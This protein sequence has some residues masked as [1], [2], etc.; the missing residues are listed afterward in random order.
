MRHLDTWILRDPYSIGHYYSTGRV[1]QESLRAMIQDRQICAPQVESERPVVE[2]LARNMSHQ[3]GCGLLQRLPP[4][5][6]LIIYGYVFGD[7]AVHLVQ[8]KGKIRHVRCQHPSASIANHRHCCPETPARWRVSS[9]AMAMLY[10]HTHASLP[11]KL[12]NSSLSLLRTCRAIYLEAADMPYSNLAF[13]VDDLHTFVAFSLAICP[14]RLRCIKRL[15]VQWTP[16]WQPMTGE[17]SASS[18]Y[19]HTH[20]DQLWRLFWSRVQALTGLE[21]LQFSLDLG[22]FMGNGHGHGHG[23][24]ANA[25]NHVLLLGGTSKKISL[26]VN[27]PWITPMLA[28]RGLKDFELCVTARCDASAQNILAQEIGRDAVILRDHLKAV[29]CLPRPTPIL[30]SSSSSSS[31]SSQKLLTYTPLSSCAMED[32]NSHIP[33]TKPSLLVTAA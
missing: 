6:R 13:D 12:S 30:A 31:V 7:E 15:T 26:D 5:I 23:H 18:I 4:E 2:P 14:E 22:R 9:D 28:V 11:A 16:I 27:E 25:A 20:N 24:V 1:W 33:V 10:P 17:E 19:S 21:H 8:L 29:M 32:Q 3:P